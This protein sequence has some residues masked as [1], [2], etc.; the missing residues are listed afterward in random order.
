MPSFSAIYFS[1]P[2]VPKFRLIVWR[3][4]Q[5]QLIGPTIWSK[6]QDTSKR[7]CHQR[8]PFKTQRVGVH[9]IRAIPR[10]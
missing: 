3:N 6:E 5:H 9:L 8:H 7:R 1:S 4:T 10:G 2:A